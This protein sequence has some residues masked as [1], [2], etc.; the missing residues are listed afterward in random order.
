M[1]PVTTPRRPIDPDV[2]AAW[3]AK[4]RRYRRRDGK[5]GVG[6]L[7]LGVAGGVAM[8]WSVFVGQ[9]PA[10]WSQA[11]FTVGIAGFAVHHALTARR[12]LCPNCSRYPGGMFQGVTLHFVDHCGRCLA[13]LRDPHGRHSPPG[14]SG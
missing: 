12:Y 3:E 4:M 8:G 14:G 7:A 2:I 10:T 11:V 9:L 13:W 6:L 1:T 5:I